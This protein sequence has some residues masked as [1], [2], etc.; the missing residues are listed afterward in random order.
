M[1]ATDPIAVEAT[2]R[3]LIEKA[4][5][6]D[7]APALAAADVDLLLAMATSQDG[8]GGD[9]WTVADL[10]RVASLG[11]N[12][13]AGTAS[14]QFK[15]G[16]GPGKAFDLQMQYDHCV[17]MA[18]AYGS[19]ALSVVGSAD[20]SDGTAARRSRIGSIGLTSVMAE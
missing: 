17:Q 13:K 9:Q 20:A 11:W 5:A 19:G 2:A 8:A 6:W 1:A 15:A 3:R 16:V 10:N 7:A 14:A 4:T 18:A 12:W